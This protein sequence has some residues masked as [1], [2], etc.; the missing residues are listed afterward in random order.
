MDEA[1]RRPE[2][3]MVG[4]GQTVGPRTAFVKRSP[5]EEP[6]RWMVWRTR[7]DGSM[8]F[9]TFHYF[10]FRALRAV[11]IYEETGKLVGWQA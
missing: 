6:G 4:H 1:D 9:V 7:E 8:D 2:R 10:H 3:I 5:P 11:R